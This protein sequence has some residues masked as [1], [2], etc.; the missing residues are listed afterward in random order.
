MRQNTNIKHARTF[1]NQQHRWKTSDLVL[2]HNFSETKVKTPTW[3]T[4]GKITTQQAN[5]TNYTQVKMI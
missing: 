2:F 4:A 5:P 1:L 3:D